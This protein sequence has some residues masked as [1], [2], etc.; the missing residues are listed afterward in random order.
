MSIEAWT[1]R[2]A[3]LL[4]TD[5]IEMVNLS[6]T[7]EMTINMSLMPEIII[8]SSPGFKHSES[9]KFH[10]DGV[11]QRDW[12]VGKPHKSGVGYSFLKCLMWLS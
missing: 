1:K 7:S 8:A 4:I 3:E 11:D 10:V 6:F 9:S 5:L 12:N 2:L